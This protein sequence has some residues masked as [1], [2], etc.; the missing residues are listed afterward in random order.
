[1]TRV[2]KENF[3][4]FS[5]HKVWRQLNP[6]GFAVGRDQVGR[7]MRKLQLAGARRRKAKRTTVPAKIGERPQDLVERSF[8]AVAPNRLWVADLTDVSTWSGF[9]YVAFVVDAFSR[10]IVGWLVAASLHAELALG[11]LEMAIWCRRSGDLSS[12]VHHS[13]RW[14][15]YVAI[16]YTE[17]LAEAGAVRSV[18]SCGD[19]YDNALAETVN[20]LYKTELIRRRGPWRLFEQFELATAEWGDWW[21]QRRLHG[22]NGGVPPAEYEED[23]YYRQRDASAIAKNSGR[24]SP[25]WDKEA[26]RVVEPARLVAVGCPSLAPRSWRSGR[27]SCLPQNRADHLRRP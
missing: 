21:N 3:G 17:R 25:S 5:V 14:V 15:Q 1:V 7:L 22:A 12:L 20:G 26:M 4:V 27:S 8:T 6:E 9:C 16:R 13:D 18:G 10:Y 2:H 24:L 23:L 19:S 11:A